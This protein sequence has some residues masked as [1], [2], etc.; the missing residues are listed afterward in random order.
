MDVN[1]VAQSVIKRKNQAAETTTKKT[2]I[3]KT[4][5]RKTPRYIKV[6]LSVVGLYLL[7]AFLTG[8]YQIWELSHK[9]HTLED[10]QK[11]LIQQQKTLQEK[12]NSL[13][14]PEIIER[15]AREDLGMVKT[16]ETIIIPAVPQEDLP[17][18]KEVKQEDMGD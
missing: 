7:V 18:T 16:G 9:L 11:M 2:V 10:E 3:R 13:N 12:V 5:R 17:E 14:D 8:G 4:R 1:K 6:C 15:I